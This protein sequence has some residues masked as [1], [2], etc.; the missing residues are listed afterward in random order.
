MQIACNLAWTLSDVIEKNKFLPV[1]CIKLQLKGEALEFIVNSVRNAEKIDRENIFKIF[2]Y[3]Y[4]FHMAD[5]IW[6]LDS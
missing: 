1:A 5:W 6:L 4:S 2:F 3:F